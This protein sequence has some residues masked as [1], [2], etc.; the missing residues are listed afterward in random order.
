MNTHL[1]FPKL[2]AAVLSILDSANLR[3]Q[4]YEQSAHIEILETAIDDILRISSIS[5]E[6]SIRLIQGICERVKH[7]K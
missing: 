7:H 3:N 6:E 5:S 2:L 4:V 1:L